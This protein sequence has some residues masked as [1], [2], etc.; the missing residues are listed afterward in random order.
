MVKNWIFFYIFIQGSSS[1][2]DSYGL[3]MA[4]A[5]LPSLIKIKSTKEIILADL[6]VFFF[7]KA[8]KNLHMSILWTSTFEM[9]LNYNVR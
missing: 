6:H 8:G 7:F 9:S 1:K 5:I 3:K 2:G 4:A